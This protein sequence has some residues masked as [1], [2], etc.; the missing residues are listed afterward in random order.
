MMHEIINHLGENSAKSQGLKQ[1]ITT[2]IKFQNCDH[3]IYIK[4]ED[5]KAI[6]FL[7]TG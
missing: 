3:R 7:R 2:Y 1:I 6:G 5:N 4:V